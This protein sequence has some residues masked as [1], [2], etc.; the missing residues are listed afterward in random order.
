[1]E[2]CF[3]GECGAPCTP[4]YVLQR[5]ASLQM[6]VQLCGNC[7]TALAGKIIAHAPLTD[8]DIAI[9]KEVAQRFLAR[10]MGAA[11]PV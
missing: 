2:A 8:R 7:G 10:Q 11:D 1:M 4:L 9:A 6:I 3:C 5:D